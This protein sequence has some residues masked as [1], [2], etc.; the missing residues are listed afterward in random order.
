MYIQVVVL[1]H[2][3]STEEKYY[4]YCSSLWSSKVLPYPTKSYSLG[5]YEQW[6]WGEDKDQDTMSKKAPQALIVEKMV[7]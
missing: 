4:R 3:F 2:A 6:E 5:F 7:E 1:N